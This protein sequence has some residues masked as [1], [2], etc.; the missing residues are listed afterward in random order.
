MKILL[1]IFFVT[2]TMVVTPLSVEAQ[3]LRRLKNAAEEGV[4]RAVERRVVS[5]V[6]KATQKQFEKAFGNL[7]SGPS[8]TSGTYDFGKIM[9]SVNMNVN[10]ESSYAFK[11]LAELEL[12]A[13]DEKGKS[14]DPVFVISYLSDNDLFT[15]M[16]FRE[17]AK[18][19][20]EKTVM[21]FDFKNNATIMLVENEEGK[22]SMAFGLDWQKMM[23]ESSV[24][25]P[26]E[27]V[28]WKDIQFEKTG[29]TKTIL[30]YSCEE[31]IGKSEEMEAV[32][33]IST[34]PIVGLNTF[35]GQSSPFISQ[36]MR[37]QNHQGFNNFP[38]GNVM[39]MTVTS[40]EDDSSTSL[41]MIN[42]DED[43][44]N[45]FDMESYPNVMKNT[46]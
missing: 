26:E 27:S 45:T 37:T 43:K 20:K 3:L 39:E 29:N 38:E 11:G 2:T 6:E 25:E 1:T 40:K 21:I 31:Y 44:S 12:V 34:T 46:K 17:G 23:E 36:R 4:A 16:E 35:W 18:N 19:S 9:E 10:T 33:W 28:E 7:Y 30:G 32:Y 24:A 13:T 8:G 41:R 14:E 5:E 22:S 15:G 42:I